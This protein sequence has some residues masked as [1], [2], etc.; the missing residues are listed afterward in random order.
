MLT[1]AI[2]RLALQVFPGEH[3]V[4]CKWYFPVECFVNLSAT[5]DQTETEVL[6][7]DEVRDRYARLVLE[8]SMRRYARP[9]SS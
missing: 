8:D 6:T 7:E 2:I 3:G 9:I 1:V 5:E 4:A